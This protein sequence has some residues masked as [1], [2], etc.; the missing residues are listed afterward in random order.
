MGSIESIARFYATFLDI[1][2]FANGNGRTMRVLFA[3][4]LER[5]GLAPPCTDLVHPYVLKFSPDD[6]AC[7]ANLQLFP[8]RLYLMTL[9][10][11]RKRS[12][13]HI[14]TFVEYVKASLETNSLE[15]S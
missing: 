12:S 11:E 14:P 1:H 10:Q 2:P 6:L 9:Q 4:I 7:H 13:H 8:K 3:W 5:S 15:F